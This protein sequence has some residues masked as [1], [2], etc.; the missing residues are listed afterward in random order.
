MTSEHGPHPDYPKPAGVASN[1]FTV[2]IP[3]P[4]KAEKKRLMLEFFPTEELEAEMNRSGYSKYAM[5]QASSDAEF[6]AE[7]QRRGMNCYHRTVPEAR[8]STGTPVGDFK[9]VLDG[10]VEMINPLCRCRPTDGNGMEC[11]V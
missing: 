7:A 8:F 11:V 4:T 10:K 2:D 6:I 9:V 3:A 1:I 5:L